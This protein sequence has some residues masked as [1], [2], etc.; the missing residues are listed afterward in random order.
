MTS[1]DWKKEIE[2]LLATPDFSVYGIVANPMLF[3]EVTSAMAGPFRGKGITKVAA[4]EARGFILASSIAHEL[5]AGM[6]PV[7]KEGKTYN[8][9]YLESKVWKSSIV[10]PSG[11][12]RTFEIER[13]ERVLGKGDSVLVVD[14]WIKEGS[15]ADLIIQM[16]REVGA[17]VAGV[18]VLFDGMD[19]VTRSKYSTISFN[20]VFP[21]T[22]KVQPAWPSKS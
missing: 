3:K 17:N 7:R 9:P 5:G 21:V 18:S 13:N 14:D 11:K 4:S 10:M 22:A 16:V 15:A 2:G 19:D 12:A 1:T 8:E 20:A 6:L